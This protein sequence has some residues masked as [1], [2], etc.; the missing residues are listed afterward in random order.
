M[1]KKKFVTMYCHRCRKPQ[2]V[3]RENWVPFGTED[4]H[5][6]YSCAICGAILKQ[7]KHSFK[8]L[9]RAEAIEI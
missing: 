3:S 5:T 6:D 8:A 4:V 1:K 9:N 2:P 7:E